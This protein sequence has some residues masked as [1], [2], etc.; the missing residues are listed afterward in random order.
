MSDTLL[1][2]PFCGGEARIEQHEKGK[3]LAFCDDVYGCGT[4]GWY[5]DT[6]EEAIAAWN[7]RTP[8][9]PPDVRETIRGLLESGIEGTKSTI[10]TRNYHGLRAFVT[11]EEEWLSRYEAALSWLDAQGG[12]RNG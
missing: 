1:P 3:W 10:R 2:C 7:R 8:A 5:E 4:E 12:G 11:T 6:P 9:I